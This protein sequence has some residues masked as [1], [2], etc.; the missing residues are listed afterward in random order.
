[1]ES[2]IKCGYCRNY[3]KGKSFKDGDSVVRECIPKQKRVSFENKGCMYFNPRD[4]I[5][6]EKNGDRVAIP[7]CLHRRLNPHNWI[8]FNYCKKCRQFEKDIKE[9]A[10]IYFLEARKIKKYKVPEEKPKTRKIKR[11]KEKPK[12]RKLKRRT[13][14][15]PKRKLKRR[16]NG[17]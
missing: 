8:S 15:K 6:C 10:R 2:S 13:T 5:Y 9:I 1:M 7:I 14:E 3:S 4:T 11:R 17:K 12:K 16:I